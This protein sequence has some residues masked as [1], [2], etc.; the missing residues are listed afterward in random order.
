M[1]GS[2]RVGQPEKED[3]SL[4]IGAQKILSSEHG[5][6]EE[7]TALETLD[8]GRLKGARRALI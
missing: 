5:E 4:L 6:N 1:V 2:D 7:T 8:D 3:A